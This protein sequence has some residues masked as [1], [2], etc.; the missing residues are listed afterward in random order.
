MGYVRTEPHVCVWARVDAE[1]LGEGLAVPNAPTH[2][3][4]LR[5]G[6]RLHF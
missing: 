3:R 4:G 6:G 2:F 1:W 5:G